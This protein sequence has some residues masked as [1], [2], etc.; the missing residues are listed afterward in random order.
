MAEE[1]RLRQ[2]EHQLVEVDQSN[3]SLRESIEAIRVPLGVIAD[4]QQ[5][6]REIRATATKAATAAVAATVKSKARDQRTRRAM[7]WSAGGGLVLL[8]V[9]TF[10]TFTALIGYVGDLLDDSNSGR[11]A[12]CV[13]RNDAVRVQAGR[14]RRLAE[15]VADPAESKVYASSAADLAGLLVDCEQYRQGAK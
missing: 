9:V 5:E 10:L 14:D 2:I 3:I 8:L 11:Y 15:I 12:G 13:T 7:K 1:E 6:Q 4:I